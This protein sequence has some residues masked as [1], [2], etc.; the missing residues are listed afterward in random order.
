MP[1][2]VTIGWWNGQSNLLDGLYRYGDNSLEVSSIV[3]MSDDGRTT[4]ILIKLFQEHLGIHL[5][6]PG[7]LRRCLFQM[8]DSLQRGLFQR[9]FER[10]IESDQMLSSMSIVDYFTA[11]WA[12]ERVVQHFESYCDYMIPIDVPVRW[13]KVGNLLMAN[14]YYNSDKNYDTM[15]HIMHDILKVQANIIPVTTSKANIR[16]VL[17]N[18]EIVETQDHI[19][20]VASYTS[21]I[22][23]LELMD[24]SADAE[25]HS[26]VTH[27]IAEAEYIIIG[28]GDLFTSIISNFIIWW[29]ATAVQQSNAKII[30][31]WNT[32]NKW[33]ETIGLSQ[34]DCLNK[35]E[36][37]LWK[38]IDYV[39]LNNLKSELSDEQ[40]KNFQENI[41]VKWWDYLFLSDRERSELQ[42]RRVAVIESDLLDT[43]T[44]YKHDTKKI[45]SV[46]HSIIL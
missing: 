3:S 14:L 44:L 13:L 21:G 31:I 30:Y 17:W 39:V 12:N 5:P 29:V 18:G 8:S 36:M 19:S 46:L 41:S 9:Y 10:V 45:V 43:D 22:A 1:K 40:K 6:P 24:C 11:I 7:D 27:V 25:H 28:P 38:R 33:W 42:R 23:D 20:N 34:L 35:I 15:L 4:G 26:R 16:A 2:I 37:F 32:T